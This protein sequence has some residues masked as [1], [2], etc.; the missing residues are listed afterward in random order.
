MRWPPT[1]AEK[2]CEC[3]HHGVKLSMVQRHNDGH[4][5][6]HAKP[7]RLLDTLRD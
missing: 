4:R 2:P 5:V 7:C 1:R 3:P 6:E